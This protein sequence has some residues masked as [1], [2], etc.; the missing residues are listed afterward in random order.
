M[1]DDVTRLGWEASRI[2]VIGADLG[3]SGRTASAVWR[4]GVVP[5]QGVKTRFPAA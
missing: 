4:L 3:T 1:A 5:A 2:V